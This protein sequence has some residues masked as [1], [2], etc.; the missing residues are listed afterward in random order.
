ME[1]Q[2]TPVPTG[3]ALQS[4][5]GLNQSLPPLPSS[6][7]VLRGEHPKSSLTC[8]DS[9]VSHWGENRKDRSDRLVLVTQGTHLPK[10]EKH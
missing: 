7:A 8:Q 6:G 1:E 5:L 9:S 2:G 3:P 4:P 10:E